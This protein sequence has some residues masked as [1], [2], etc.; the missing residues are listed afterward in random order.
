METVHTSDDEKIIRDTQDHW[1]VVMRPL[2]VLFTGWAIFLTLFF[3]AD[4][5]GAVSGNARLI[6]HGIGFVALVIAHHFFFM[7]IIAWIA[8]T[9]IITGKRLIE[10]RFLPFVEDDITHIDIRKINELDK[11]KH[12]LLS[13][14]LNYGDIE[15]K[16]E[17]TAEKIIFRHI[18]RPSEFVNVIEQ[19]K[20]KGSA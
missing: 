8:S 7:L 6:V 5:F 13:N 12:G 20:L 14:I 10:I 3:S 18:P 9:L 1:I 15:I 11:K 17:N 2:G 19:I 16:L 4:Y